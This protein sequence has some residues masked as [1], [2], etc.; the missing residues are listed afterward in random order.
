MKTTLEVPD[1]IFRRA[2][3]RAARNS[4]SLGAFVTAAI[5]AKLRH[6]EVSAAEKP[7]MAFAG[8]FKADQAESKLI[9]RRIE[10]EFGQIDPED[11]K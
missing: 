10:K 11:W 2:K 4:Q 6:D 9:R 8:I 7:W 3:A 1:S 5:E